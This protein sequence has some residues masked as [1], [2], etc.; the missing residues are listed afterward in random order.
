MKTLFT[1]HL[2]LLSFLTLAAQEGETVF[3]YLL[4]PTSARG[5]ALG[6]YNVS[7]VE[8]DLSLV[9][10]NPA[11]LSPAMDMTV[12][13]G[14]MSYVGDIGMGSA[15]FGKAIGEKGAWGA[16]VIYAN[17]GNMLETVDNQENIDALPTVIGNL[18]ASD[19]CTSVFFSHQLSEFFWGGV[20]AKF[21][22]SNYFHNTAIGLGADL[23]IN[24][25]HPDTE[26]SIGVVG[27]NLG[28]QVKAYEEEL[29]DLPWD[30]QIGM[31]QRLKHAPV[32]YSV[33]FINLNHWQK[34]LLRHLVIG[35]ELA[36][37]EN[38]WIAAGFNSKRASDF[39]ITDGNK[40]AGFSIGAGIKVSYFS[41][42]CAVGAYHPAAMSFLLNIS[43]SLA[44]FGL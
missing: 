7:V 40:L 41:I 22:Y 27:K 35:L 14:Y 4:L 26:L 18:N 31:S 15:T 34:P 33:S 12:Q 23:G 5:A 2:F 19:I 17:Y 16:G 39:A 8:N 37:V 13:A 10:G 28:R 42:G 32:R 11:L 30:I 38:L 44:D 36:P 24:Y 43:T 29:A 21:V 1:L 20:A 3:T 9:H 25:Y 6:G